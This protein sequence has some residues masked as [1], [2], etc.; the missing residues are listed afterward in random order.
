MTIIDTANAQERIE[1]RRVVKA[2]SEVPTTLGGRRDLEKA[3]AAAADADAAVADAADAA[4][5]AL[6]AAGAAAVLR[7]LGSL[8]VDFVLT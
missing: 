5:A 2:R 8:G 3:A 6:T 1:R 4:A 7:Q